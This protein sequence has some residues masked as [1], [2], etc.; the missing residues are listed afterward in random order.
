[1]LMCPYVRVY[2]LGSA[3]WCLP[4]VGVNRYTVLKRGTGPFCSESGRAIALLAPRRAI[5]RAS[6]TWCHK[7]S[8]QT[9]MQRST[10]LT[11]STAAPPQ[12]VVKGLD[13]PQGLRLGGC[14]RMMMGH[15]D[16]RAAAPP[17]AA[18]KEHAL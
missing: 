11:A 1:M 8:L 15:G 10:G 18:Q 16:M 6:G 2:H 7:E 9:L 12:Q 17:T 13:M 5:G 14:R 3:C 4:G